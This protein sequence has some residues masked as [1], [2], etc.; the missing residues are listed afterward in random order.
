VDA[1]SAERD[2]EEEDAK[3]TVK[4]KAVSARL[5]A[6]E[7]LQVQ[8]EHRAVE[9]RWITHTDSDSAGDKADEEMDENDAEEEASDVVDDEEES[10]GVLN[11]TS[12]VVGQVAPASVRGSASARSSSRSTTSDAP[13]KN[14]DESFEPRPV[15][16]RKAPKKKQVRPSCVLSSMH[17]LIVLS[18]SRRKLLPKIRMT[19]L[20]HYLRQS[21]RRLTRRRC[22]DF[23]CVLLCIRLCSCIAHAGRSH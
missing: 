15:P 5:A 2:R 18:S 1:D 3:R 21:E 13:A 20:N 10:E 22:V 4:M 11:E 16:K 23:V 8:A 7:N 14:S 6:L 19:P 12:M 9:L 17:L